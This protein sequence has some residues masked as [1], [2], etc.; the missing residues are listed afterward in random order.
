VPTAAAG[1]F[2]TST[3]TNC[4]GGCVAPIETS[5]AISKPMHSRN[6]EPATTRRNFLPDLSLCDTE[7]RHDRGIPE[8]RDM[9]GI[10]LTRD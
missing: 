8:D 1:K 4:I 9:P 7:G 6:I 2:G 3:I 10:P 5:S